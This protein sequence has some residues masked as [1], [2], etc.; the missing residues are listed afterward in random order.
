MMCKEKNGAPGGTR[1]PDLLVRRE[2]I[3]HTANNTRVQGAMKS[4]KRGDS[5]HSVS[6]GVPPSSRTFTRTFFTCG[7]EERKQPFLLSGL[8]NVVMIATW[9]P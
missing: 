1:T 4:T 6:L 2:K 8:R 7:S 3:G 9:A 5:F